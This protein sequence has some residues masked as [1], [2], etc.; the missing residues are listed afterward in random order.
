[1][2]AGFCAA[3]SI[4]R[5]HSQFW[6][7]CWSMQTSTE[8]WWLPP[9]PKLLHW[10]AAVIPE[11]GSSGSHLLREGV[12]GRAERT[13]TGI[14]LCSPQPGGGVWCVLAYVVRFIFSPL[15]IPSLT[16]TEGTW[17]YNAYTTVAIYGIGCREKV[18]P[19]SSPL[20]GRP[21]YLDSPLLCES[22]GFDSHSGCCK[23]K[24]PWNSSENR[25]NARRIRLILCSYF[26]N[27]DK[28]RSPHALYKL[29][30]SADV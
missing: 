2:G 12:W 4:Y 29:H 14:S 7:V 13:C 1:M 28:C 9:D 17:M 23:E 6:Q 24:P 5:N 25:V 8:S 20:K 3:L 22:T 21:A 10:N 27:V 11:R 15:V 30:Y 19:F 26:L 18:C 16:L